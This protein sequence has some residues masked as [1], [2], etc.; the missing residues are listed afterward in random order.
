MVLNHI[1]APILTSTEAPQPTPAQKDKGKA[2]DTVSSEPDPNIPDHRLN[3]NRPCIYERQLPNSAYIT[4][5][6]QRLQH[7]HYSTAAVSDRD[8]DHVDFLA[9]N[10]VF[11]S[12]DTINHRFKAATIRASLHYPTPRYSHIKHERAGSSSSSSSKSHRAPRS[13]PHFLMHAP[14]FLHGVVSPETLQW[15]YSLAGS[16]GIAQLP[17]IASLS[18]TA[19]LNGRFNRYEMLRVQG[20]VRSFNGAPASQIVWTLEENSLQRSGLPREFTFAMLVARTVPLHERRIELNVEIEPVLQSW[21]T[22]GAYPGWWLKLF[23]KYRVARKKGVDFRGSVGQ[24]FETAVSIARNGDGYSRGR[25]RER[26]G[27]NFAMLVNGFDEYVSMPGKKVVTATG[28]K[29]HDQNDIQLPPPTPFPLP[30]PAPAPA[31]APTPAMPYPYPYPYPKAQG[32]E[33]G[34]AHP[35]AQAQPQSQAHDG[36]PEG[37]WP[38]HLGS[39]ARA[40]ARGVI[41][42][43]YHPTNANANANAHP[44]F[45][46]NVPMRMSSREQNESHGYRSPRHT[47]SRSRREAYRERPR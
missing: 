15:N 28:T 5:H 38:R 33:R 6:V 20:S 8:I 10:F 11:H 37:S 30:D 26:K 29:L 3:I 43:Q 46:L 4:A 32:Q 24:R 40:R 2:N 13:H 42:R 9:I 17:L 45:D 25:E 36:I 1:T 22:F 27:F 23:K 19:A 12:P 18:P 21:F 47:R 41:E 34:Q 16:L 35:Q 39:S 14:H 31:P 7:G 44:D